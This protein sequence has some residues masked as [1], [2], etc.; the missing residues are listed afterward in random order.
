MVCGHQD[1]AKCHKGKLMSTP[2]I[3]IELCPY[4]VPYVL[5]CQGSRTFIKFKIRIVRGVKCV[6]CGHHLTFCGHIVCIIQNLN[7]REEY[8]DVFCFIIVIVVI[9]LVWSAAAVGQAEDTAY[10]IYWLKVYNIRFMINMCMDI[11]SGHIAQ[12]HHHTNTICTHILLIKIFGRRRDHLS[13]LG[14]SVELDHCV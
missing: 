3:R 1:V 10:M 4:S 6:H 12:P 11:T 9:C 2:M 7:Y 8:H 14:W 5:I 13:E